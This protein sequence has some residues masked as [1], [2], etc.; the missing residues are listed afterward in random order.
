[1]KK[2][3]LWLIRFYRRIFLPVFRPAATISPPAPSMLW[4]PLRNMAHSRAAGWHSSESCAAIRSTRADMTP[5]P[6]QGKTVIFKKTES[7]HLFSDP[8]FAPPR[9]A[10]LQRQAAMDKVRFHGQ[11]KDFPFSGQ[12]RKESGALHLILNW[13]KRLCFKPWVTTFACRLQLWSDSSIL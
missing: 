6:K 4:R 10:S 3:M 8:K 2:L 5:Y 7:D 1:M 9:A 12:A 13:R 11:V